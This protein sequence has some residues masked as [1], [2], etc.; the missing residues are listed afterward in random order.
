MSMNQE[1][2]SEKEIAGELIVFVVGQFKGR[3]RGE[4][5]EPITLRSA[6]TY[7]RASLPKQLILKSEKQTIEDRLVEFQIKTYL[8]DILVVEARVS[9]E[10]IFFDK[11]LDYKDKLLEACYLFFEKRGGKKEWVEEYSVWV[12]SN[13][14]GEPE[15]FFQW[16]EK[17]ASFL[18][19][20]KLPLDEKEINQTLEAQLKYA[21]NDLVI[22]DW[23][24]AFI[25]DPE[26][27]FA[28]IVELLELANFQLLKYRLLDFEL[29]ERLL[30][31][32][33]IFGSFPQKK[34]FLGAFLGG[35]EVKEGMQSIIKI[36]SA[37]I[38]EFQA[39]ERDIKLIGDWYW[40]RLYDLAAKKFKFEE[41]R[42]HIKNKLEA[43]EDI[44]SIVAERF[45]WSPERIEL[46]GWF[47]LLLGWMVILIFD[48]WRTFFK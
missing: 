11:A 42:K 34:P 9:L 36:R 33:K 14:Q 43:M 10:N 22:I 27:D 1:F 20:E 5:L 4:K 26:G 46:V 47:L 15:Q 44:Y 24:G 38:F 45:S 35:K 31:V 23:D 17:I 29:D 40:A 41:W 3:P 6:P 12:V 48:L 39:L 13:Y 30:E 32:A 7:F 21:K 25:F 16:K 37:S 18:K 28:A 19:S 8:P 2:L